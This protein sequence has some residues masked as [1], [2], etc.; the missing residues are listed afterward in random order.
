MLRV[1]RGRVDHYARD[2]LQYLLFQWR[3]EAGVCAPALSTLAHAQG[4]AVSTIQL[5]LKALRK[6]KILTWLR[7][8]RM[9]D[10]RWVQWTNCYLFEISSDAGSRQPVKTSA[11]QKDE[12]RHGERFRA[13]E[14]APATRLPVMAAELEASRQA[15]LAV[16]RAEEAAKNAVRFAPRPRYKP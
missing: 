2:L 1:W 5:R 9:E 10:G 11:S 7:R 15:R 6:A 13:A 16:K 12:K 8:G 14:A 4:V 3:W